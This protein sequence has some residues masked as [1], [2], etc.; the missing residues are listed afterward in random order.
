MI[1]VEVDAASLSRVQKKLGVMKSK[2]PVVISRALNKTAVSARQRLATRA[3]QAYTVKSGKFKK[4]MEIKRAT[5]G[6]LEAVIR[7]EGKPLNVTNFKYTAPK[8]GAKSQIVASGGLKQL[9]MGNIKAFKGKNGL[10]WQRRS[11]SR[12]PI[13]VLKS[14]SIPIMIGSEKRVYG[15]EKKNIESDLKKYVEAQIKLLVG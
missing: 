15:L 13:K 8:S 5:S 12:K 3:Q 1:R 6:N 7:S 2:A 10:I 9:I 4:N 14:N 11:E